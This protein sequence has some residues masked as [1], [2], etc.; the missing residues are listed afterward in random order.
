MIYK[1]WKSEKM[2]IPYGKQWITEK[3]IERVTEVLQSDFLT[4]GPY[5]KEFEEQFANFVG[6]KYAVAVANGTAALHLSTQAVGVD[7]GSEVLTSPMTFAATSNSILYSSG[8]PIFVDI[9]NRGLIAESEIRKAITDKTLGIMPVDYM[10]LPCDYKPIKDTADDNELFVIEDGCHALGA[11]YNQEKIGNGKY[12]DLTVFS[13]HPVKHITT[14]EGGMITTNNEELYE[15]LLILRTHGITKTQANFKT[16][17]TEP[18]YQE[19]QYL[20]YNYRL[21]DIQAALGIS[22]LERIDKIVSIRR[23]IAKRY[24]NF[25]S[26]LENHFEIIREK[27]NE[28]NSYH[29]FVVKLKDASKRLEMFNYLKEKGI[30][31]QI[32]YI[33]VYWHPYYKELGYKKGLCTNAE[34]F[35]ERIISLPIFPTLQDEELDYVEEQITEFIKN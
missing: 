23:K 14:G 7:K 26:D 1:F 34:D 11:E 8:K 3:D 24:T 18:W 32:H 9:D 4:T 35:Y 15:K 12:T 29:L 22:Q 28:L 6:A 30:Y 20:G 16:G 31:C 2:K 19:M 17:R 5:V 25:F 33:P 27:E 13:F 21:T 10:G